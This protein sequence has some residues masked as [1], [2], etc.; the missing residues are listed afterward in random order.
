MNR[1]RSGTPATLDLLSESSGAPCPD[2]P[3]AGRPRRLAD[4]LPRVLSSIVLMAAALTSVWQGGEIFVAIWLIP[5]CAVGYE[6]QHLVGGARQASRVFV[7]WLT[8]VLAAHFPEL[9]GAIA[10]LCL[11]GTLA[12]ILAKD[13][14]RI[15]SFAGVAYA[16]ALITS[17]TALDHSESF[18]ALA[19]IWL[20]TTVWGTDVFAYFA[21]RLIGGPKLWPRIS[22]SK[23]WSG[24]LIGVCAGAS[25]GAIIAAVGQG[26]LRLAFPVFALGLAAAAVSQAG[27]IFESCVKRHFGVKD[28]SI[29]IPGHG[30][31]MDRLDGFVAAASFATLVGVLRGFPSIAEGLFVWF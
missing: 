3:R 12:A 26:D 21:G 7:T 8:L 28:S 27:D 17:I 5:A 30:G 10:V 1:H 9:G 13:G 20:F 16:G 19:M 18:G 14:R 11:G 6:W 23:T 31:F 25:L 22:P 4:L 29:L 15:W 2:V 24:T